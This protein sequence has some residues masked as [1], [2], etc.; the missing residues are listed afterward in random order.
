M[1]LSLFDWAIVV[2]A[3]IILRFISLKSSTH[4]QGVADFLSANRC[5]G[6]YLLTIAGQMGGTGVISLVAM[7]EMYYQV[8]LPPIWWGFMGIPVGIIILLTGWTYWRFRETRALTLA[9]FF[10]M[11]YDRKF[12]IFAG[13]VCWFSGIVNFGIFPAVAA[14]FFI[15]FC[16]LPD[17]FHIP[18][19]PFPISSFATFMAVDLA[20]ALLFVTQGGQ[21]TVMITEFFQGMFCGFAF[22]VIVGFLIYQFPWSTVVTAMNTAPPDASMLNP[23]HSS[24]AK[25]F[26]IWY[27]LIG[28]FGTIL[29]SMSWQGCSGFQSSAKSPHEARMGMIIGGWRGMP[30]TCM[31]ILLALCAFAVMNLPQYSGIKTSVNQVLAGISDTTI[32]GQMTVPVILTHI[33][34]IGIKGLLTTAMLFFSFTCHDTYMHSWGSIFIQDVYMPLRN[35]PMS[36]EQH[37]RYLR[38]SIIG[39]AVFAFLFSLLFPQ[40]SKILFFF[41]GTG[42]IWL[43]GAG[44]V[45]VGGLYWKRGTT[46]GAYAALIVGIIFGLASLII[47]PVYQHYYKAEFPINNQILY[48]AAMCLALLSYIIVSLMTC[49]WSS[50]FNLEKML[51][52]GQYATAGQQVMAQPHENVLLKIMGINKD[53]TFTDKIWACGLLVWNLGWF[54]TF[55]I[56]TAINYAFGTSDA[57]W[58]SFWK[59]YIYLL[60]II[61]VPATIWFS[62]GGVRDIREL[63][64]TL[65]HMVRDHTDDG[66]VLSDEE[67]Q[68][69]AGAVTKSAPTINLNY[70]AASEQD[71]EG[72]KGSKS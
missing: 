45:I 1:N 54:A 69:A 37:I 66:R 60:F 22:L 47:P 19:L 34:P 10:E 13:F 51:N 61:G 28:I 23:Y 56:M 4:M 70:V 63:F 67:K 44:S 72:N 16:G 12:R 27:F 48:F 35:K 64:R 40:N 58:A 36:P 33:L 6:R 3:V 11:R 50:P 9:Q 8:G 25:D 52:R 62:I 59:F 15:Y 41:A 49:D 14:R 18:G 21:I 2:V 30:L 38:Y 53:F 65:D 24:Q 32:R 42:T 17:Y 20:L 5:A 39:V 57:W 7:F 26:N 46:K 71:I 43:G 55:F 29:N 31:M 68:A